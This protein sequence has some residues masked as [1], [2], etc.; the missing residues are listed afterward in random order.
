M[1]P[2]VL[3]VYK[4]P[5]EKKRIGRDYDGGYIISEIPDIKYSSHVE[6]VM[7]FLSKKIL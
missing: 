1:N 6:Y 2:S 5:F 3:T 7:I 4:S